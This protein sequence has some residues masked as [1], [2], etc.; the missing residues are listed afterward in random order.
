MKLCCRT[1]IFCAFFTAAAGMGYAQV[2][3]QELQR[4]LAPVN[5][6][7][8]DGPHAVIQSREQIRQIGV[9]LGQ[10]I[11]TGAA[12]AGATD[13]Y[14]V[15]HS[16]SNPDGNKLDADVFGLGPNTGVDHIRNLRTII[17][18][19]LQEAYSYSASDAELLA[20]YITIYNA[21]YRGDWN[22]FSGRYK[23]AVLQ[24]VNAI[25]AGI[26]TR[27]SE[28]PGNTL[29]LIP[30][31]SGGLSSIDTS[32]ISDSRVVDE[33]RKEEGFGVEQRRDM[34]DLKEREAEEAERRA[35]EQREAALQEERAIAQERARLE[36][37]RQQA[38]RDKASGAITDEEANRRLA[39]AN[40]KEKELSDREKELALQR[41][42]AARQERAAEQKYDEAQQDRQR[43]AQD[44]QTIIDRG[45]Q[46]QSII[47]ITIEPRDS[48]FG[49]LVLL[50]LSTR[51][52]TRRSS[53][54]TV[55]TRTLTMAGGKV[56]AIAGENKGNGAVRLV[57]INRQTLDMV[58]Q[59]D[60]DIHPNSLI[61][62]SGN[63]LYAIT[64]NLG[65]GTYNLGRFNTDLRL[66]SK[67]AIT[68]HPNASV[69]IQEG[70]LLTQK[71]DGSPAILNPATLAE[72]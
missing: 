24:N 59:G 40:D 35:A 56:L 25:Q 4:N 52:E 20:E 68:V 26:S 17:Q 10:T 47:G 5:F 48:T 32:A 46:A 42:E 22:Y 39:E 9:G 18:G 55:Y 53:L 49:K 6:I 33:L 62:V 71:A 13:R 41:E 69:N 8:F 64:A 31:G 67:S 11:S 29:M 51:R 27:Y 60:D 14:F 57:E 58:K 65:N 44:Q 38:E 66:Q 3:R 61:W 70:N 36:Q 1:V 12:R 37:E 19:Y 72:K 43:I 45:N 28:W 15:I 7:S 63:D 21:V 2:D 23:N 16:V 54:E 30:L 50:D 34:V